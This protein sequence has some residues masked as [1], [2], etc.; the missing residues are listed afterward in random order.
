MSH[1]E[2][3]IRSWKLMLVAS[4]LLLAFG[5][6]FSRPIAYQ[7]RLWRVRRAIQHRDPKQAL[8]WID[9]AEQAHGESGELHFL[10]A[11]ASRRLEAYETTL[12]SLRQSR[13]LG[14]PAEALDHETLLVMAESAQLG[15][16][17][18][19]LQELL[20]NTEGDVREIY[21]ALVKGYFRLYDLGPASL[22]LDIWEQ[23][24]PKDPQPRVFRGLLSEHDKNW[25][26][27]E[28]WFRIATE[29]ARDRTDIR[30][31]LAKALREQRRYQESSG[32]YRFVLQQE[33]STEAY[34]G[35][36]KCLQARGTLKQAREEFL[37][38]LEEDPDSFDCLLALGEL[39][40]DAGKG[41]SALLWLERA[42]QLKPRDYEV[43]YA[44]AKAL[45]FTGQDRRAR[46]HFQFASDARMALNRVK[47]FREHVAAHPEDAETRYKIGA[48]LLAFG[49]V[50]EAIR[51]LRSVFQY[52]PNHSGA[53]RA[54]SN[55]YLQNGGD[56]IAAKHANIVA[57]DNQ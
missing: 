2:S 13:Q 10:R 5:V 20:T 1:K 17:D 19:R 18:P 24:Y 30:L 16:T 34:F 26:N 44:I 9:Q 29:L 25:A 33:E 56:E 22:V 15:N 39:E 27:A 40:V 28:S 51:W 46:L 43:R 38:G 11:R 47:A 37:N 8:N 57:G 41:E 31:H 21:E 49:E 53:H 6:G 45:L 36:G 48:A 52:A 7:Y 3:K 54:L 35:L 14:Y 50:S 55:Y 23:D 42:K 32:H 4:F 12:E